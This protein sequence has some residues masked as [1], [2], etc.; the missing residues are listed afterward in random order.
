MSTKVEVFN[1]ENV[2]TPSS[3]KTF[4]DKCDSS[5]VVIQQGVYLLKYQTAETEV[6]LLVP[7]RVLILLIQG[8][9]GGDSAVQTETFLSPKHK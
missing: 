8:P 1:D 9:G 7:C 5:S 2:D 4:R 3:S 6:F